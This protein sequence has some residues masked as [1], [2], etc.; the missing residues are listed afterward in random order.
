MI[1]LLSAKH[2]NDVLAIFLEL[3][4]YVRCSESL[5]SIGARCGNPIQLG[6]ANED[7]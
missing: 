1:S 2:T 7:V 6:E 5:N 4:L 3:D